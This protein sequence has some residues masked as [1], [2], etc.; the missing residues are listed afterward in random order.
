MVTDL[1]TDLKKACE[2]LG[3]DPDSVQGGS[4]PMYGM[5]NVMPDRRMLGDFLVAYQEFQLDT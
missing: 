1:L 2:K 4:A 5:A 3:A